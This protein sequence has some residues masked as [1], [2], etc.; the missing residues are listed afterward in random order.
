MQLHAVRAPSRILTRISTH[1]RSAFTLFM[2]FDSITS[3]IHLDSR[4]DISDEFS[5]THL[6][7][8]A[9]LATAF[10]IELGGWEKK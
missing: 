9:K 4:I 7:E 8:F 5:F 10:A 2:I 3:E 1:P 6:L